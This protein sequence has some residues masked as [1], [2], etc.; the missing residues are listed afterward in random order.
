MAHILVLGVKVP[1]T[2][3]GQ[4]VLVRTLVK[5]LQQR[6]H[7]ADFLE[8]PISFLPKENLL[9]YA[10][11]WRALQVEEFSGTAIDLV[12]ATKFPSYYVRHPRKSVW[13]VHQH[14]PMYELYGGRYCDFS[15]DP[16]DEELR[17]LLTQGDTK[18]LG[19]AAYVAGISK[20]VS[21]R[22]ELFNGIQAHTLYPPL[23]LGNAYRNEAQEPYILSVGRLC[24]IKRVDLMIKAMPIIHPFVKLKIV[25]TPDEPGILDYYHNE[26]DKHHL[27]DRIEFLGRVS[28]EDL[29]QL[30][31]R[32]S[33][34]YY[35][36]HDEDYGYV[37]LEA[38][39]SGKPVLTAKDS[40]GT[41]EFVRHEENGLIVDPTSD[42][43]GHGMNRFF[44]NPAF[45]AELGAQGRKDMEESGLFQHGWEEVLAGL[46]SPLE[47]QQEVV[48]NKTVNNRALA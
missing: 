24:S 47:L 42:A 8:L 20:N 27:W 10:A 35:A 46:L 38:F 43:M 9:N 21:K 34:V 37:T 15:E 5:Q 17:K 32:A 13:L 22:L 33:A 3:G 2:S 18:V 19:E 1:F 7:Q 44:E 36:P 31:A 41:L 26:I 25:G 28:D 45:A 40:G 11:D 16:R 14:R 23:P 6:G 30:Y 29:L 12:I 48:N 39:A 4:D